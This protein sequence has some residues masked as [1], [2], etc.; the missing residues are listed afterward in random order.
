MCESCVCMYVCLYVCMPVCF[1][2]YERVCSTRC[3]VT[4][5]IHVH[6]YMRLDSREGGWP[7]KEDRPFQVLALSMRHCPNCI[8]CACG[9]NSYYMHARP[10]FPSTWSQ[11][12][13][14]RFVSYMHV[15]CSDL[16]YICG[17]HG[18]IYSLSHAWVPVAVSSLQPINCLVDIWRCCLQSTHPGTDLDSLQFLLDV[19]PW[20]KRLFINQHEKSSTN[21]FP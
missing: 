3:W 17:T 20:N 4:R 6:T 9:P 2:V 5:C 12:S 19:V 8:M 1:L 21:E 16:Y 15:V 10:S 11:H 13:I 7:P 14:L 18:A